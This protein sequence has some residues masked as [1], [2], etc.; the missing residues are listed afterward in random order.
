MKQE[1]YLMIETNVIK[2]KII[3]KSKKIILNKFTQ[4]FN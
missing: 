2:Q 1:K 4:Q 3:E